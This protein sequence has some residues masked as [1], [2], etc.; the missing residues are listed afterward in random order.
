MV[1]SLL[2]VSGAVWADEE[3]PA[4]EPGTWRGSGQYL[5]LDLGFTFHSIDFAP[6]ATS[7]FQRFA[8]GDRDRYELRLR[9]GYTN[10]FGDDAVGFGLGASWNP[11]STI[12]LSLDTDF[13]PAQRVMARQDYAGQAEYTVWKRL[14]LGGGYRFQ[15]F[16]QA[17]LH[18]MGPI[19]TFRLHER[20]TLSGRYELSQ[21]RA[22]GRP[23]RVNHSATTRAEVVTFRPLMIWASYGRSGYSFEAAAP[24]DP[25]KSYRAH[26]IGAGLRFKYL[27]GNGLFFDFTTTGR[28]NGQSV[29][30]YT[31]GSFLEF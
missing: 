31:L 13:A 8:Y 1:A 4:E 21:T 18:R 2:W 22:A 11:V 12:R 24:D 27:M 16:E 5:R 3:K 28:D 26:E 15:D 20:L 30:T 29:R 19:V 17:N 7:E 14:V 6:D 25:F 23:N 10:K 9:L